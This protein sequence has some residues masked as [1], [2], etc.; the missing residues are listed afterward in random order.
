MGR[1]GRGDLLVIV[2]IQTPKK[3]SK[4]ERTNY[5]ELLRLEKERE[6]KGGGFFRKILG[7]I[8]EGI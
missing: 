8:A 5:Q 3:L 1:H 2:E 4:E 6:E 7:K